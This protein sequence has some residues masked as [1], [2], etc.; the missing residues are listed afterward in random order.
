MSIQYTYK[1]ELC[2]ETFSPIS[3]QDWAMSNNMLR[4]AV[5][6]DT[7]AYLDGEELTRQKLHNCSDGSMG[8]AN[9]IGAKKVP[10]TTT[11]SEIATEFM[12]VFN[13]ALA[14]SKNPRNHK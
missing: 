2:G 4:R 3:S 8:I 12:D 6:E 9:F 1:C 14:E 5:L 13:Q 7:K 11:N 10:D